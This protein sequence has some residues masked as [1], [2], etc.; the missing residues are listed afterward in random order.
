MYIYIN[1]VGFFSFQSVI[2]IE[3]LYLLLRFLDIRFTDG[4]TSGGFLCLKSKVEQI[5]EENAD[6]PDDEDDDVAEER[7]RVADLQ[8]FHNKVCMHE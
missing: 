3:V 2:H 1:C 8:I 6:V 4:N 5:P 7:R